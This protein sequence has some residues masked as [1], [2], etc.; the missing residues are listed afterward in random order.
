M[1]WIVLM[2]LLGAPANPNVRFCMKEFVSKAAAETWLNVQAS[3]AEQPRDSAG[4]D[5][6]SAVVYES[7]PIALK[8]KKKKEK[9]EVE[10]LDGVVLE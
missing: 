9:F 7:K 5:L 10:V 4:C 2:T 3:F 6:A 8:W 1:K